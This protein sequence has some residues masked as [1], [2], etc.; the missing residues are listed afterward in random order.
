MYSFVSSVCLIRTR[1][2]ENVNTTRGLSKKHLFSAF[3]V[4]GSADLRI[5]SGDLKLIRTNYCNC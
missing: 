4:S 3:F 1:G 2:D 5:S